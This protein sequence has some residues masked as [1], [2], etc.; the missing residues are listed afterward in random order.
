MS[1]N[2]IIVL[3]V[4]S[5]STL[6]TFFVS[7]SLQLVSDNGIPIMIEMLL[8]HYLTNIKPT[9]S[10]TMVEGTSCYEVTVVSFFAMSIYT[11]L[12]PVSDN[13]MSIVMLLN[14]WCLISF[15]TSTTHTHCIQRE[16]SVSD[17][18]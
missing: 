6:L 2:I 10:F 3:C 12:Q 17:S 8:S 14:Y 4:N 18:C 1:D 15:F 16:V 11:P 9:L 7:L 13:E 5:A